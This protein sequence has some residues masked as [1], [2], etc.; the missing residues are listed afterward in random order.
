MSER[1]GNK[2][3][4]IVSEGEKVR[5]IER[6]LTERGLLSRRRLKTKVCKVLTRRP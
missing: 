2:E 5:E 4:P 1:E 3:T 6:E